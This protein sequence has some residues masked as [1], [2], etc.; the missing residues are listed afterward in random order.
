MDVL[1]PASGAGPGVLVV[2]PWWG[3]NRTTRNYGAALAAEGFVAALPDIFMGDVTTSREAAQQLLER[4]WRDAGARMAAAVRE[5]ATH[6]AVEGDDV[7]G[8]GF[9]FGGF[10]LLALLAQPDLPLRRIATYYATHPL[11]GRHVPVLAHFAETDEFE[12]PADVASMETALGASG[13]PNA[14]H[15]YPNTRHWFAEAD[16]PEFDR[17]AADLAFSRT[18]AFLRA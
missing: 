15:V 7:A 4:H 5:L 11:P 8:V 16:R 13:A 18:L 9:S 12:T 6:P 14:S 1:T 2:H 3:L 17:A 10:Q